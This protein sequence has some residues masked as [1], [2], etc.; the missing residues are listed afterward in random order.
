[1]P[2]VLALEQI[3]NYLDARGKI[4]GLDPDLIHSIPGK[5]KLTVTALGSLLDW[6]PELEVLMSVVPDDDGHVWTVTGVDSH[7]SNGTDLNPLVMKVRAAQS[8]HT[9]PFVS[10]SDL[11]HPER[12]SVRMSIDFARRL[13]AS[14][15]QAVESTY[16]L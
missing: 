14:L 13:G 5:V 1:M 6:E 12:G 15:I 16:E 2:T 3:R 7:G 8:G 9:P 11:F 10:M 4:V